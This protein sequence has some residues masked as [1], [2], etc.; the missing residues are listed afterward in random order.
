MSEVPLYSRVLQ[1]G[2][3]KSS[4]VPAGFQTPSSDLYGGAALEATQGQ[5]DSFFSQLPY[6]C[7]L[8]EVASVR[9]W[10]K[11][12]PWVT[13]RVGKGGEKGCCAHPHRSLWAIWWL[14]GSVGVF[15]SFGFRLCT[16][17]KVEGLGLRIEVDC[18]Q[19]GGN[20]SF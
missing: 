14:R 12:R 13:S 17:F 18:R 1:P 10:L 4:V 7:Y 6:K 11:I 8:E 2:L 16:G 5:N 20:L 15:L 3:P 19:S 9:D